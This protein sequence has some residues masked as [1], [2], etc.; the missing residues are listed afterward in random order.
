MPLID[1]RTGMQQLSTTECWALLDG[2]DV[3]RLGVLVD[4]L[5]EIYPVNFAVD[6]RSIVFRTDAGTKRRALS[7]N[8]GVT[9]EADA[10]DREARTGWS[11]LVKGAAEEISDPDELRQARQLRLDLWARGPKTHWV[12]IRPFE[13]TGRRLVP[14]EPQT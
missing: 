8:T 2:A 7:R 5:P 6:G 11:V 10:L 3:G 14:V 4:S 9:F 13:V 1:A 12:R